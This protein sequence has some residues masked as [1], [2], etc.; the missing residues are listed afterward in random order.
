M[1]KKKRQASGRDPVATKSNA[2][3]AFWERMASQGY[4]GLTNAELAERAGVHPS[5]IGRELGG[6]DAI[7]TSGIGEHDYWNPFFEKFSL[8]ANSD[9]WKFREMFKELMQTNFSAFMSSDYMQ[10][11]I[12]AQISV[13][14]ETLRKISEARERE[15]ARLLGLSDPNYKHS[16]VSFRAVIAL[17][18]GGIYYLVLHARYNKSTVCG[19]DINKEK[20]YQKIK[21][22]IAYIIDLVWRDAG[23]KRKRATREK[24]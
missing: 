15:G 19:I 13:E 8:P 5:T 6:L 2:N 18:L 7:A 1:R 9:D 4:R 14:S 3:K 24:K 21:D 10:H 12:L 20:D 22:T 17:I 11:A 16:G 23:K